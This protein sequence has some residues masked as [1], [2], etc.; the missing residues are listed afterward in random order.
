[1]EFVNCFQV[2][3]FEYSG[4]LIFVKYSRNHHWKFTDFRYDI[5]LENMVNYIKF[6]SGRHFRLKRQIEVLIISAKNSSCF[7]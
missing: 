2:R 5:F 6:F 3:L 7:F 1:M 4:I